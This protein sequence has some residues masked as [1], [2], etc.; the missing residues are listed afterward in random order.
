MGSGRPKGGR[1]TT[2]SLTI[3]SGG[4]SFDRSHF[5]MQPTINARLKEKGVELPLLLAPLS[6]AHD[7][8]TF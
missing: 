3:G 5:V 6:V 8:K 2:N 1:D 4:T 7:G